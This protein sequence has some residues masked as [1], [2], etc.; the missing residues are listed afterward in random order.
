[1][2][3]TTLV[4]VGVE[5]HKRAVRLFC[6]LMSFHHV[7]LSSRGP[8]NLVFSPLTV[9]YLIRCLSATATATVSPVLASAA[10]GASTASALTNARQVRVGVVELHKILLFLHCIC[11][12]IMI[13][14]PNLVFSPSIR[15]LLFLNLYTLWFI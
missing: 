4:R 5:L 13:P 12:F 1:M 14:Y 11:L 3:S 10:L 6:L 7:F 9:I 2:G 8:N 15:I